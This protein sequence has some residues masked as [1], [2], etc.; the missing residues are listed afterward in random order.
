[1]ILTGLP[2]EVSS[3]P[4][5]GHNEFWR[6][7]AAAYCPFLGTNQS[8]TLADYSPRKVNIARAA[9]SAYSVSPA[10]ISCRIS[11]ADTSGFSSLSGHGI[12]KS[13]TQ[14]VII[15]HAEGSAFA[16]QWPAFR[17][18]IF[19]RDASVNHEFKIPLGTNKLRLRYFSGVTYVNADGAT[20]LPFKR[21]FAAGMRVRESDGDLRVFID[22]VSDGSTTG[23]AD[24]SLASD[25]IVFHRIDDTGEWS[26]YHVLAHYVWS[27]AKSDAFI[28]QISLDWA[29]P[30]RVQRRRGFAP[31]QGGAVTGN[32]WYYYRQMA[33]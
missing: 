8:L 3:Q 33:G 4:A 18:P 32:P 23:V 29:G 27:E 21:P 7:L 11:A 10:G 16:A 2:S 14:I 12:T 13:W 30:F 9:N 26:P 25:S 28:R 6:G 5:S 15:Y 24:N 31:E 22:G 19:S 20:V 17:D 1:M